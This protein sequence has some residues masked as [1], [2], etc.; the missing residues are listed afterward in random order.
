[1]ESSSASMRRTSRTTSTSSSVW[2]SVGQARSSIS[3]SAV[4]SGSS[5]DSPAAAS[6]CD[7]RQGRGAMTHVT[8]EREGTTLLVGM[9]RPEKK[10]AITTDMYQA[11]AD[12]LRG[13]EMDNAVRAVVIHG[14]PGAFTAGNDLN[15]FL[16][17]R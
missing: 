2:R 17:A 9:N 16:A 3:R 10:N 8:V 11:M 13:A 6:P 1:M 14:V 12:A 5:E 7:A 15:D 4:E